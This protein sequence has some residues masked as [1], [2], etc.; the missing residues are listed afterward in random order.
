MMLFMTAGAQS[1]CERGLG[2]NEGFCFFIVK[3]LDMLF[4]CYS[5]FVRQSTHYG[6]L[7][8]VPKIGIKKIFFTE[9]VCLKQFSPLFLWQPVTSPHHGEFKKTYHKRAHHILVLPVIP[10]ITDKAFRAHTIKHVAKL[11]R[12]YVGEGSNALKT[13]RSVRHSHNKLSFCRSIERCEHVFHRA[14]PWHAHHGAIQLFS[15]L[16]VDIFSDYMTHD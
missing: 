8:F 11:C 15:Q 5:F 9:H 1:Y 13:G 12:I 3:N 14:I 6:N 10:D 2:I 4:R 7:L 16:F